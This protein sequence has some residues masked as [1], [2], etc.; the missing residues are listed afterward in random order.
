MT[1]RGKKR[2]V[3]LSAIL[4]I[5]GAAAGG[6]YVV[7]RAQVARIME[8]GLSEGTAAFE[9][10]NYPLALD[11]LNDYAS[12]RQDNVEVML[13]MAKARRQV[14]LVNDRH[15]TR[16]IA[17]TQAASTAAPTDPRPYELLLELYAEAGLL[18]ERVRA[19]DDLLRLDPGSGPA[20]LARAETLAVM[21][22]TDDA[23][24]QARRL[25][26]EKPDN[27]RGLAVLVELLLKTTRNIEEIRAL[28]DRA[29]EAHR[30]DVDFALV[31]ASTLAN[32]QER[33][34]AETEARRA[35]TL[36]APTP[37]H[38]DRVVTLLDLLGLDNEANAYL[39]KRSEG[40]GA[41]SSM[42]VI[43]A[44]RA[45]MAGDLAGARARLAGVLEAPAAV[46][47]STLKDEEK[48][49]ALGWALF[50][51][52]AANETGIEQAEAAL[53]ARATP[54]AIAWVGII[55]GV[56]A[57]NAGDAATAR[58]KFAEV[59]ERQRRDR[60]ASALQG[61]AYSA[62]G[63]TDRAVTIWDALIRERPR[64]LTVRISLVNALLRRGR[65]D[66]AHQQ[67]AATWTLWRDRLI[68]SAL[69]AR[70]SVSMVESG[71]AN[72]ALKRD[73]QTLVAG[74]K[75]EPSSKVEATSLQARLHA[76][77]GQL[78]KAQEAINEVLA[79]DVLPPTA[80]ILALADLCRA[81]GLQGGEK[82]LALAETKNAGNPDVALAAARRSAS[83][84]RVDEGR[85]MLRDGVA[86]AAGPAKREWERRL[87]VFLDE[88]SDPEGLELL[89]R[90]AIASTRD[91]GAQTDLLTSRAA[92]SD[93]TVVSAAIDRLKNIVGENSLAWRVFEARRL[94]TFTPTDDRA[95]RAI[96]VLTPVL[97][98]NPEHVGALT[99]AAEA[100]QRVSPPN[101][102]RSAEMLARAADADPAQPILRA[103]HIALLQQMGRSEE[104]GRRLRELAASS[105]ADPI[106][107]RARAD[108]FVRQ[109]MW[110]EAQADL[111]AIA[112]TGDRSAL[113]ALAGVH[114]K[115]GDTALAKATLARLVEMT[116]VPVP[117]LLA[118]AQL[119]A[120]LGDVRTGEAVL[121]KLPASLAPDARA[122]AHARFHESADNPA[123]SEKAFKDALAASP[124]ADLWAEWTAWLVRQGR[125]DDAEKALAAARKAYPDSAALDGAARAVQLAGA[126]GDADSLLAY[127]GSDP[128]ILALSDAAKSFKE[129]SD[130]SAYLARLAAI[131]DQ[132]PTSLLV[133]RE[134]LRAL[135]DAGDA[136]RAE[137]EAIATAAALPTSD[138]AAKL[139]AEV[140]AQLGRTD[141]ALSMAREWRNRSLEAPADAEIAIGQIEA[142][143]GRPRDAIASL[144][145]WKDRLIAA[146]D[147]AP[148]PLIVYARQLAIVGRVDEA[149]AILRPR[150]EKSPYW[151]SAYAA[152]GRVLV[153][154]PAAA[155][156]WLERARP[157]AAQDTQAR[158]LLGQAWFDL[159]GRTSD[160][161][162]YRKVVDALSGLEAQEKAAAGLLLATTH[163]ILGNNTDADRCYRLAVEALP[164]NAAALNNFAYFLIKTGGSP[165]EAEAL[166]ERAV[167]SAQR[168][169][170]AGSLLAG[171]F[172]TLGEASRLAKRYPEAE[173]AFNRGLAADPSNPH[174]LLGLVETHLAADR[175]SDAASAMQRLDGALRAGVPDESSFKAR[176]D[177]AR[178]ALAGG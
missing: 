122:I 104:A 103:R 134:L 129:S 163:D 9:A 56:R 119:Y 75:Q 137:Q 60:V 153:G 65:I 72:D 2:L 79:G 37:E 96:D 67:A 17:F 61:E 81:K 12:K 106:M 73:A 32:M 38:V 128:A 34:E 110:P 124:T 116:D 25:V 174:L 126:D 24:A 80:D 15:I 26:E 152:V 169:G 83:Q 42:A 147:H 114:A 16:A 155:R 131:R 154:D 164:D 139:A 168:E 82:L 151:A 23:L 113:V 135:Q 59:I 6:A 143:A 77:L 150:A 57:L 165:Q 52:Q 167:S 70:T 89:K 144:E 39:A 49:N 176:L 171:M 98:E 35:A 76:A 145:K 115:Q 127:T 107:R 27:V 78:D 93:E 159:A 136:A 108:L 146:A 112:E 51:A 84:G 118:A 141:N 62:L 36:D 90:A 148:Q 74:L 161:N 5:A 170:L 175:R 109:G 68:T 13:M 63:D 46:L 19:A 87:A 120:Q 105:S 156:T 21:G 53:R 173:Q 92:W 178:R 88:I 1:K 157:L 102:E 50:L 8:R 160:H 40:L 99:L 125:R 71:K 177:A 149:D 162:D 95:A 33:I 85:A 54:R 4:V 3:A 91:V 29:A 101:N 30:D 111:A 18:G 133:R 44:E 47:A 28:V 123:N 7:H 66:D 14:P 43:A 48:D 58:D 41:G 166:A 20:M 94:L 140:L 132:Y 121:A 138:Q 117:T 11:R 22:R 142:M 55:E 45:W 130:R 97:R 86:K 172:H 69:L 10:R 100:Y 64:W 31:R 158:L